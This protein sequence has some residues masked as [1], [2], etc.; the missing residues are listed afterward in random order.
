MY[1]IIKIETK[2]EKIEQ[3]ELRCWYSVKIIKL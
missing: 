3:S 1:V 2:I